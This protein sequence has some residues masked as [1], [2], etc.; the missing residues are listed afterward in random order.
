MGKR[1]VSSKDPRSEKELCK[2]ICC[3]NEVWKPPVKQNSAR[4]IAPE[5]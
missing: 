4:W 1:F 3:L 5:S 2:Y